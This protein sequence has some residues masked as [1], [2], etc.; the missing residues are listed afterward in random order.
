MS[1]IYHIL[2]TRIDPTNLRRA[3]QTVTHWAVSGSS[4]Y[5]CF[6]TVSQ[7]MEGLDTDCLQAIMNDAD[8]VVSDGMPIVWGLR[9]L[10]YKEASR[11]YGPDFTPILLAQAAVHGLPVGFYGGEQEVLDR[12]VRRMS[13]RFE[14]L[15]I[16]YSYSP[17]FRKLTRE[18]DECVVREIKRS[19]ARLLFVG[20]GNPKQ[21]LWMAAHKDRIQA[22]MLGVGAAFDF[23]AGTKLQAPRWMMRLGMEWLFRLVTEPRRLGRR[24]L[25]HN[26]RFI[27][28]FAA[29][30][31]GWKTFHPGSSHLTG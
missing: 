4:K 15:N 1:A 22:V 9:L 18:E 8:L 21:E 31:L 2:G 27:V 19:G 28:L 20:I 6:A 10:G 7:V 30:L 24:Y 3:V 14:R 5:V 25:K 26:P 17:P 23:L 11:V 16:V 29:Q 12:F 13:K